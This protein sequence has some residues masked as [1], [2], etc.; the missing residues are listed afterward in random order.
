MRGIVHFLKYP[1][2]LK[3][4][5]QVGKMPAFAYNMGGRCTK[6]EIRISVKAKFPGRVGGIG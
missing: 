5:Q 2:G 4:E 3:S 6:G 1:A